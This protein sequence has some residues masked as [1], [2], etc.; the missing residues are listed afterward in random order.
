[1]YQLMKT[2]MELSREEKIEIIKKRITTQKYVSTGGGSGEYQTLLDSLKVAEFLLD[3]MLNEKLPA[4][5]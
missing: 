1:M 4:N 2:N 3:N 5:S